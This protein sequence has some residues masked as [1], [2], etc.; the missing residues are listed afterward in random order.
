MI[1]P[2]SNEGDLRQ[3]V[4]HTGLVLIVDIIS[5]SIYMFNI[6]LFTYAM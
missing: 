2:G 1:T 4:S 3:V 5:C 6:A